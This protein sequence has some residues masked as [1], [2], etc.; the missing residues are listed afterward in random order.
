MGTN[1]KAT[2]AGN[3]CASWL[4]GD[5]LIDYWKRWYNSWSTD[6]ADFGNFTLQNDG[7]KT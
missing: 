2:Q 3:N 4:S 7:E 1:D 5:E 6:S